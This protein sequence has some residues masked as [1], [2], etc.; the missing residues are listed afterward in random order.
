MTPLLALAGDTGGNS[1]V[2]YGGVF[3]N[4]TDVAFFLH[5]AT[6]GVSNGVDM[7][8]FSKS[9]FSTQDTVRLTNHSGARLVPAQDSCARSCS[10]IRNGHAKVRTEGFR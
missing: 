9:E 6:D 2:A 5:D 4:S 7:L 3:A 8:S 1:G 10:F